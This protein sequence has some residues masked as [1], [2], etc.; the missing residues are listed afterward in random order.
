VPTITGIQTSILIQH[1]TKVNKKHDPT[2]TSSAGNKPSNLQNAKQEDATEEEEEEE[3]RTLL[4]L[5]HIIPVKNGKDDNHDNDRPDKTEDPPTPRN[6]SADPTASSS[7]SSSRVSNTRRLSYLIRRKNKSF[8]DANDN[9]NNNKRSSFHSTLSLAPTNSNHS[10]T[11]TT[12]TGIMP[13]R[14]RQRSTS[15]NSLRS[16]QSFDDHVTLLKTLKREKET[17]AKNQTSYKKPSVTTTCLTV[18][19][20]GF[21]LSSTSQQQQQLQSPLAPIQ[22]N[23]IR[24]HKSFDDHVPPSKMNL[25]GHRRRRPP[26]TNL[27]PGIAANGTMIRNTVSFDDAEYV[28]RDI[29]TSAVS[30]MNLP[31]KP[32][33][34]TTNTGIIGTDELELPPQL[35]HRRSD[36][37]VQNDENH[38]HGATFASV[39]LDS[40]ESRKTYIESLYSGPRRNKVAPSQHRKL[41][42][43]DSTMGSPRPKGVRINKT[44]VRG[45]VAVIDKE[46]VF[47]TKENGSESAIP[48]D[49]SGNESVS[50]GELGNRPFQEVLDSACVSNRDQRRQLLQLL[51]QD[52]EKPP[53]GRDSQ[54]HPPCLTSNEDDSSTSSSC[55]INLSDSSSDD[56]FTTSTE[57]VSGMISLNYLGLKQVDDIPETSISC[58]SSALTMPLPA[59]IVQDSHTEQIA[60]TYSEASTML[61]MS[62]NAKIVQEID[63][64]CNNSVVSMLSEVKGLTPDDN[65]ED[66]QLTIAT[67]EELSAVTSLLKRD[68]VKKSKKSRNEKLLFVTGRAADKLCGASGGHWDLAQRSG[69]HSPSKKRVRF[70]SVKVS[71]VEAPPTRLVLLSTD[72]RCG[73]QGTLY[74]IAVRS[75]CDITL[76]FVFKR[77]RQRLSPRKRNLQHRSK[78]QDKN[79]NCIKSSSG[80]CREHKTR[81]LPVH[82]GHYDIAL[83]SGLTK[84]ALRSCESFSVTTL[85]HPSEMKRRNNGRVL[86]ELESDRVCGANGTLSLLHQVSVPV[87]SPIIP[88][89]L[90][91]RDRSLY[92]IDEND[93]D[94]DVVFEVQ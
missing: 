13:R 56:D 29:A 81:L 21:L 37:H 39:K 33:G 93:H 70:L 1:S 54:S 30:P 6:Q 80:S 61:P 58:A 68:I 5:N 64:C 22:S 19:T 49:G 82:G 9:N 48:N 43:Y 11:G 86:S 74:D 73:A 90:N 28:P 14:M 89:Y 62:P 60:S 12:N 42:Y 7:S 59:S 47:L 94:D 31:L 78:Y 16:I 4:R 65:E 8:D 23:G 79:E 40:P 72:M 67:H 3:E 51:Q 35:V 84:E 52:M 26:R 85:R 77:R 38:N 44:L 75:G 92:D 32:T 50:A 55:S 45:R 69:Y 63:C 76:P 2:S 34:I 83:H 24:L 57:T 41:H 46:R 36:S 15:R 88:K 66:E 18:D 17:F 53:T 87:T 27:R 91:R 20:E 71:P 25:R 10:S